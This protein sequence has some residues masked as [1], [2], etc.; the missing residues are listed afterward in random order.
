MDSEKVSTGSKRKRNKKSRFRDM[1]RRRW[2]KRDASNNTDSVEDSVVNSND[3]VTNEDEIEDETVT[4]TLTETAASNLDDTSFFI[5]DLGVL[6]GMLGVSETAAT[7]I[8]SCLFGSS[9]SEN[10]NA[11][12]LIDE[13]SE[14]YDNDV[15]L[16]GTRD[17]D[18]D[19]SGSETEST[20]YL[21]TPVK[22]ISC[23]NQD[24]SPI[25]LGNS[26]F[27]CQTTQLQE[28]IDQV[29]TTALCYTPQCTG[30][31]VPISIKRAG[32][33][34]SAVVKFSCTGC[35]ERMLNLVSSAEISFSRRTVCSLALQVAFIAGGCMYSQYS[36][37]LKQNLGMSVVNASSFYETIKLL[38][39]VINVMLTEM[40]SNA[41]N[42]MK[43]LNSSVVGSWQRAITSSD[44]VWLTRGKFSQNCTFTIRNYMNNSL[45]Y[46]V[47]LSMR[48]KGVGESQLYCGTAKGAEGHA[49]NIAFS[50]AKQEG[51]H[52][53]VQWQDGDSSSAKSFRQHFPDEEKSQV[54]LCGGHVARAHT[55]RLG[56]L[57][58]Q[59]SFSPTLQDSYKKEFPEV[60]TVKCHCPKRHSKNCGC[61]SKSFIRGARTNFFYCLLQSETDPECFAGRLRILGK[62]HA[63]DIH[64]W[65]RGQ[66]DFHD[67]R[68]CNCGKCKAEITCDG[69]QY[70]AKNPLTCPFHALA[71]EIECY[72]RASQADQIIHTEL[73][74][75]HSNYP[76]ASHNVLIRYRLKDK[77]LQSTHY[78]VS[79][80][81]GLLQANMTW[82]G[83]KYGLSYHW[84]LDLFG[85]LKLPLFD[86]MAEALKKGNEVRAKNLEKKKTDE[87]K[88]KRTNWKKARVQEQEERKEW[89]RRQAVHHTYGSEDEDEE[90]TEETV[91]SSSKSQSSAFVKTRTKCKCG[92]S[93][94]KYTSHHECPL[95]KKKQPCA[96]N[97][98]DIDS[99]TDAFDED[100]DTE[101]EIAQHFCKCGSER[102]THSRTCPLNPRNYPV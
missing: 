16:C 50:Q 2:S 55:K 8:D 59:K 75:G 88:E 92:S 46:Y 11:V 51:M 24:V 94:H 65:N 6:E 27:L 98:S 12:E 66:C 73:G 43:M 44:G 102:G 76:E 80:N 20:E 89:I 18:T 35:S 19:S 5:E 99:T 29:N 15:G 7:T 74:R 1:A 61:L 96:K 38:H 49:A 10:S 77:Y 42:E 87:A 40:C 26:I 100:T 21:P 82:L 30:K 9:Q 60:S 53:E 31:L 22:K 47:H 62:Y 91:A 84:I 25:E 85:R 86:G 57:A 97:D 52:I 3:T 70:H 45:L 56:D 41:K 64:S 23:A 78:M 32:L 71:Y 39:P 28:L 63:R 17:S 58:K 67:L 93:Q 37:I 14:R 72:S 54:I 48:G 68:E 33:G 90:E 81:M 83:K 13:D 95:N 79:T 36:K 34:G 4:E 69:K 101:E